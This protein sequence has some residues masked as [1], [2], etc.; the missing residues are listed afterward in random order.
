[1]SVALSACLGLLG[2]AALARSDRSCVRRVV[3]GAL[4]ARLGLLGSA[5]PAR[6]DRSCVRRVVS[7]ALSA[8]LGLL[9]SA[10][11]ARF[12]RS[13]VR[14][15]VS[16]A[17]SARLGLLGSAAP[18]RSDRL[19]RRRGRLAVLVVVR[20]VVVVCGL[21]GSATSAQARAVW[22]PCDKGILS[23][24]RVSAPLDPTGRVP[25]RVSLFVER[26]QVA[27]HPTATIVALAGGPGQ[28]GVDLFGR[29]RADFQAVL[30][31]RALV[32]F[33]ERGIGRSGPLDCPVPVAAGLGGR[34]I[35][36]CARRLGVRARFYSTDDTVA[37]L[38][39][40]RRTLR[41]GRIDLYG[42]SYGTFPATQ[43][44]R[45]HPADVAH[46]VLDST[47]PADG[48]PPVNL[49][50]YASAR[51][52]LATICAVACPALSPAA[53][54]A[55]WLRRLPPTVPA[56]ASRAK[57]L[58]VSRAQAGQIVLGALDAADLDPFVRASIPAALRLAA[59]GD[60]AAV[61]RLGDIAV[62]S[63]QAEASVDVTPPAGPAGATTV[64]V[65]VEPIATRCE[66]ERFAWATTDSLA[67]RESD[68]R[69]EQSQLSPA[70]LAPLAPSTA[71]AD[72]VIGDCE[73]WP[74]SGGNPPREPGPL[75]GVP[76]LILSGENDV[77]TPL[78][79]AGVLA[80]QIPGAILLA[81]PGVGHAV[82]AD[83]HS[84]CAK[85]AVAAFLTGGRVVPCEVGPPQPVDPLPPA[86][87]D[88]LAPPSVS[89][90]PGDVLSACVLTLRHDVGL[91]T[92][93]FTPGLALAGSAGGGLV[94]GSAAGRSTARLDRLSYIRSV[95][96]TGTLTL[97]RGFA[98]GD[99]RVSV[100][101]HA[102]G[103]LR[104]RP[105][106][107][108]TGTLGGRRLTLPTAD[109]QAIDTAHGLDFATRLR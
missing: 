93:Y 82:L 50:A 36:A 75:A 77:R 80:D 94:V 83:D 108:I 97:G 64:A 109:R 52:Q 57:R 38:E 85:R 81:V 55:A 28:S 7:G 45:R 49:S 42:V 62:A 43:Y 51:R 15:V 17:L 86:R 61:V 1:L 74:Y 24:A 54:L 91:V 105:N 102:Y 46:L 92:P 47:V 63:E 95:A 99:L 16:V 25:G 18:A 33:D 30:G 21:L 70:A 100:S 6:F 67:R 98:S 78:E 68:V 84:D 2:S 65:D 96:L 48:D 5:A 56:A 66:D 73:R 53:D 59:E 20:G 40:I 8:C 13:C 89:G 9:G 106:G 87:L 4:S 39:A 10:A 22:R 11:L 44:A 37:D 12:D 90:M 34:E 71:V 60:T 103:N 79:Q 14:R 69:R 72:A 35:A 58:V 23:C 19:R 31:T 88:G 3:S 32:M 101:G 76:T 41:L 27:E 107:T 104:L 29:F 26:Y